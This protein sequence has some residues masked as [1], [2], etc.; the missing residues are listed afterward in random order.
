MRE[1]L[2]QP[3]KFHHDLLKAWLTLRFNPSPQCLMAGHG[4]KQNASRE[5]SA[6]DFRS[7][8]LTESARD[9]RREL[10]Q[11]LTEIL[12]S[13]VSSMP[14]GERIGVLSSG[15]IDSTAVIA[16]L[17]SLGAR[18]EAFTIGFDGEN[19][20]VESASEA[21]MFLRVPHHVKL[22][23]DVLGST[24]PA[25]RD[26]AEPYRGACYYYDALKFVKDSGF[27]YVF[28][29][30]G[31]DEF[32]G[33]YDFRYRRIL[34]LKASGMDPLEAYLSGAHS[35][36]YVDSDSELFGEK[37]KRRRIR[38][39]QLFSYFE[40][41]LSFLDQ[42][43]LA[44]YNGKCRQNFI[45]LGNLASTLGIRVYYPWLDDR[46]IDFSLTVPSM[47]K[48]DQSSGRTKILFREAMKDLLPQS[49]MEKQKQG[50]GPMPGKVRDE[51]CSL[52]PQAVLDGCM[53]SNQFVNREY[54]AKILRTKQPSSL[55][56]N[57]LWDLYT[58]EIFLK[59]KGG[60]WVTSR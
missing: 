55:E 53:V 18:P 52:A 26:L 4:L 32:F 1:T 16:L 56:L 11:I 48:F 58:L 30:L 15:G 5:L 60:N 41:D 13:T 38:W 51:L 33:G 45:P 23:R 7:S 37:L 21:A 28:D 27:K 6:E 22:L 25:N 59:E 10:R 57:K 19:D 12:A 49:T 31:V 39:D 36:D 17:V 43:F 2:E 34:G 47:Y 8:R 54:Y 50:F 29:G 3:N 24:G 42:I 20:E 9:L 14:E 46:L 44:D 40:N 35:N